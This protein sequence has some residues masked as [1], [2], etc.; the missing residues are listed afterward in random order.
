MDLHL[1]DETEYNGT[2]AQCT[3]GGLG[4][5]QGYPRSLIRKDA[6]TLNCQP[7]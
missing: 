1:D 3:S 7:W 2:P 5:G 4:N 6:Q